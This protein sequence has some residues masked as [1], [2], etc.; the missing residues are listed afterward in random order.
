MAREAEAD[1]QLPRRGRIPPGR[2]RGAARFRR[3]A[4]VTAAT[5][6]TTSNHQQKRCGKE[7]PSPHN[8]AS[9]IAGMNPT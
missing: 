8:H 4:R 5:A 3:D 7:Y 9:S 1:D 2:G 6:S